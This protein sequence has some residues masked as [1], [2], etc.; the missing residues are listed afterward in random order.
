MARWSLEDGAVHWLFDADAPV[1]ALAGDED[2]VYGAFGSGELVALRTQDGGVRW[3]H[4]L[5]LGGRAVVPLSL[6]RAGAGR[7]LIGAVDGRV[8][9]VAAEG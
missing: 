8:L 5:E 9:D 2:T 7:V 6:V 1:T 4:R 3:R